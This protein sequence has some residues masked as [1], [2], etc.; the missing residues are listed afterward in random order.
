MSARPLNTLQAGRAVACLAVLLLHTDVTLTLPK[1]L[2]HD[3]FPIF[4]AGGAGVQFFFVLSG[5][6]ILLVHQK[7]IDNPSKVAEFLWKRFRRVC[8]NG[9]VGNRR[10]RACR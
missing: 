9:H 2:G 4:N 8:A 10:Y 3:I 7:D 1:Y 6:V 5:F